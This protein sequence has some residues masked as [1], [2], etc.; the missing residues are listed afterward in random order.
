MFVPSSKTTGYSHFWV[1]F[2]HVKDLFEKKE[3]SKLIGK[4]KLD[5]G[6]IFI[7]ARNH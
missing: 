3:D 6:K 2:M 4:T 1:G 5:L 7:L